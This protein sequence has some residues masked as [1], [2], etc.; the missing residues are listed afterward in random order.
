VGLP[1][2]VKV[3]LAV[4]VIGALSMAAIVGLAL[5]AFI[6]NVKSSHPRDEATFIERIDTWYGERM[7][8]RFAALDDDLLIAE[9]DRACDW[10]DA[11]PKALW[12]TDPERGFYAM[13]DKY[14]ATTDQHDTTLAVGSISSQDM[15]R[16][17]ANMAWAYLCGASWEFHRP[18]HV[19]G[20]PGD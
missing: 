11:Q 16:H 1:R 19:L 18:Y 2:R 10:L 15:R 3:S 9:G 13:L 5:G 17:V 14:L 4:V 20:G 7:R 12:H 8:D 6:L